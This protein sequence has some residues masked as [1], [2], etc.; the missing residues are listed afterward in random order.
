MGGL[1]KE[2]MPVLLKNRKW[3]RSKSACLET[4]PHQKHTARLYKLPVISAVGVC[5]HGCV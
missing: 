5:G 3:E 4:E 1:R 2:Y